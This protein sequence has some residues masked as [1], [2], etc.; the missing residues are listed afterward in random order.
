M[1]FLANYIVQLHVCQCMN[2]P[3]FMYISVVG[4]YAD[5]KDLRDIQT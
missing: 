5:L 4:S 3:Y 1:S 2:S